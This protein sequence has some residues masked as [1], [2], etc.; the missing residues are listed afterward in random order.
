MALSASGSLQ[1]LT[2][3][4]GG[5]ALF[6]LLVV[7][8]AC[9]GPTRKVPPFTEPLAADQPTP[10]SYPAAERQDVV[11]TIHG[12][13]VADPYR[14]LEDSSRP[15]VAAWMDAENKLAR[16]YLDGLP[17]RAELRE[18]IAELY[19]YDSV[20]LPEQAGGKLFVWKKRADKEK[21]ILFVRDGADGEDRL[22]LDPNTL[23]ADGSTSVGAISPSHD[24]KYLA[25]TL[26]ENNADAA[27]LYV[28]DVATGE[29]SSD[30][31]P[32]ARY[33]HPSWTPDNAGFYYVGLPVD[34]SISPRDMPGHAEVRY[35]ALG[36]DSNSDSVWYPATGDPRK[37]VGVEVTRDGHYLLVNIWNG[38]RSNDIYYKRL[39][40]AA[41]AKRPGKGK[42]EP[43]VAPRAAPF[44]KLVA[45]IDAV[46]QAIPYHGKLY[47]YTNYQA[48]HYRLLEVD[49]SAPEP[50]P[51]GSW[52]QVIAEDDDSRLEGVYPAGGYFVLRFLRKAHSELEVRNLDGEMLRWT[53]LPGLGTVEV[54]ADPDQDDFYYLYSSYTDPPRVF[55]EPVSG[56]KASEWAKTEYPVDTSGYVTEQVWYPSKDGTKIS[57]FLVRRK[58]AVKDGDNP[59]MLFGYGGFDVSLTPQ[60]DPRVV[61][62]LEMGGMYAVPNLR[63]GGEYGEAWHRAGMLLDKQNVFDDFIAAAEWLRDQ[64]WTRTRRLAIRGRSNGGLL[65]GAV[66]TQRPDLFQA[67]VCGVPLLDMVRYHLV[68][69]GQTWIPEYGSADDPDQ[70]KALYAYSPYHHVVKDTAYPAFLMLS[71]DSDDRVDPMHA[72]K[73][74]AEL[75]WAQKGPAPILLRIEKHAGHAGAD[76]VKQ[77]VDIVTDEQAFLRQQLD[78]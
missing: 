25:Y 45:G 70:F 4:G 16:D 15:E 58:A 61:A 41:P 13:K 1:P 6:L 22:L 27:T 9:A 47:L 10:L 32:G 24:G 55:R 34:P 76:L 23:S 75:Q 31:I 20:G 17:G 73:F 39:V 74:V 2:P 52:K 77:W 67:V 66:T 12:V 49:L 42:A 18:K 21:K 78:M 64:G 5:A 71:T 26:H 72:R 44:R 53:S 37:L 33:A 19:Y 68:G 59:T 54:S 11:D 14:W 62:W 29:N 56:G 50:G 30:R 60:F 7:V 51:P 3:F 48:P 43:V 35:H 46:F 63:G 8:A 57:M 69:S 38:W 28:M 36:S 65:M 40:A